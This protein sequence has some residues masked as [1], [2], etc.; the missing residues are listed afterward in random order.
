M[1]RESSNLNRI[2]VRPQQGLS[3]VEVLIAV[4]TL[5]VAMLGVM[6]ALSYGVLATDYAGAYT[7]ANQYGRELVEAIRVNQIAFDDPD[8]GTDDALRLKIFNTDGVPRPALDSAPFDGSDVLYPNLSPSAAGRFRRNIQVTMIDPKLARIEAHVY[9]DANG[10]EKNVEFVAFS[11]DYIGSSGSGVTG[12]NGT[13]GGN[14]N[15]G[16]GGNTTTGGNGNGGNGGNTTGGNT[17]GGNTTG[18]N[19]NG[20]G[21]TGNGNGGNGNG[22]NGG[23]GNGNGG[24]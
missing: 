9:W 23:N 5:S 18:G 3:L 16:N 14:G 6:G 12:G 7:E 8:T 19:G 2:A 17:T 1:G 20:N 13:T 10:E 24:R 4:V 15:G 22:G 11:R 21:S